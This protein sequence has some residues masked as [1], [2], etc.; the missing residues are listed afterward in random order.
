MPLV[1]HIP[2]GQCNAIGHEPDEYHHGT[3][4]VW[5]VQVRQVLGVGSEGRKAE[6]AMCQ[7][8]P[9]IYRWPCC[10]TRTHPSMNICCPGWAALPKSVSF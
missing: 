2:H 7:V 6:P 10:A 4:C 3:W 5:T 8:W 1:C 9:K